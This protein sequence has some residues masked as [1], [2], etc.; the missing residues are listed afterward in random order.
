M[1]LNSNQEDEQVVRETN[2]AIGICANQFAGH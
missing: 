2:G 1:G